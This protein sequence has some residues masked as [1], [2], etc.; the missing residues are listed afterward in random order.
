[1]TQPLAERIEQALVPDEPNVEEEIVW[2]DE[3]PEKPARFVVDNE[4]KA[5]W[6][7]RKL[8]AI[9]ARIA[10]NDAQ[11][12]RIMEQAEAWL[13]EVNEAEQK[14][15]AF[16]ES[17]LAG[18]HLSQL[19][20]DPKRKTI[21]LPAGTLSARQ[22]PATLSVDP[23]AFLIWYD[24]YDR[25]A[26]EWPGLVRTR[27]EPD[28]PTIKQAFTARDDGSLVTPD[29]EVVDGATLLE[30]GIRFTAKTQE[31]KTND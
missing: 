11:A 30:G 3:N 15:A 27:R 29:G 18:F 14:H 26:Q 24:A 19:Q 8:T 16:F 4:T 28:K 23:D 12:D 25:R 2:R 5:D 6:A 20:E 17:L 13:R 1:M 31:G 21:K 22:S 10:E 9:R 7:I